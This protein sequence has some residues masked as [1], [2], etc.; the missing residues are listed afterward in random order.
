[1]DAESSSIASD[2]PPAYTPAS[3]HPPGETGIRYGPPPGS[4]PG[5]KAE[6]DG[7][8]RDGPSPGRPPGWK[9]EFDGAQRYGP[10]PGRPAESHWMP[11]R[12]SQLVNMGG[13]IADIALSTFNA[14][15]QILVKGAHKIEELSKR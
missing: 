2:P 10:P 6:F 9:S 13:Q 1:M 5:W 14:I 15:L 8:Q 11:R 7:A 4:P 3:P 12:L